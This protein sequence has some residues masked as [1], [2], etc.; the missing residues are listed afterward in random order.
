MFYDKPGCTKLADGIYVF[1]NFIS[2]DKVQLIEDKTKTFENSRNNYDESLIDWYK[3]KVTPAMDELHPVWEDCSELL[4]PEYVIH[5]SMNLI[6]TRPGDLGMFAHSDSPGRDME[7]DLTQ[8]DTYATCC[9]L[10]YG[11]VAYF[12][13]FEGGEVY[14]PNFNKDG[15]K[16]EKGKNSQE[17]CLEYKPS[18]GDVIVHG[19]TDQWCHGTRSVTFGIRYAFSN[20]V[21]RADENPGTFYNYGTPEYYKQIGNKTNQE[22]AKW[23]EPLIYNKNLENIKEK[24]AENPAFY[25]PKF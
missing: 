21:L 10:D 22:L 2:K 14:Y 18:A 19:A 24:V 20:F 16:K 15:T 1:K 4:A 3:D 12:G 17:D 23:V 6:A 13:D 9:I 25:Q 11:L 7:E 5:P 8:L